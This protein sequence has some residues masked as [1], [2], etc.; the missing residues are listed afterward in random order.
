MQNHVSETHTKTYTAVSDS[1]VS[2]KYDLFHASVSA[3][4]P[5]SNA[6]TIDNTTNTVNNRCRLV[7]CNVNVN[8]NVDL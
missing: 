3:R 8:V 2:V 1:S 5:H 6:R 7:L 4:P